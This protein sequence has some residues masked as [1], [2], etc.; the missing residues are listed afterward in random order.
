MGDLGQLNVA[1][2][3]EKLPKVQ[4]SPNL[5]TLVMDNDMMR[6]GASLPFTYLTYILPNY[7]MQKKVFE[8]ICN[9]CNFQT[10]CMSLLCQ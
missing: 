7:D 4:K 3:F 10:D 8:Y 5:A 9:D 1:K 6:V 2:G